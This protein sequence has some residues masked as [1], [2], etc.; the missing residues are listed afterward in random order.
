MSGGG[1]SQK[2]GGCPQQA[3]GYFGV[4][5]KMQGS[6]SIIRR[7]MRCF[8]NNPIQGFKSFGSRFGL[9]FDVKPL[10][11]KLQK[12]LKP[13]FTEAEEADFPE[14]A[15]RLSLGGGCEAKGLG[16]WGSVHS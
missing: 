13:K 9:S 2:R 4:V 5:G 8:N 15:D 7:V 16:F 11:V 10:K 3:Q 12:A 6:L 14:F 1:S